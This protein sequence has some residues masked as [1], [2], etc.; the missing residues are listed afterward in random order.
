MSSNPDAPA[1]LNDD[2]PP[3][4]PPPGPPPS[5]P[6]A[7][8]NIE[9]NN[10]TSLMEGQEGA[11][12][13]SAAEASPE[14]QQEVAKMVLLMRVLNMA[15][16]VLLITVSIMNYDIKE[17]SLLVLAIYSTCGGLLVCLLETQLK[18]I[19][20][21]IAMNFG[22]LFNA[23]W[24]FVFYFLMASIAWQ[25]GSLFDK[26]V[27]IGLGA[28]AL[29]NTYVLCRYPSY[30]A[31]RDKIAEEEDKRIEAKISGEVKKQAQKQAMASMGFS[32]K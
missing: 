28:I 2:P 1:W 31:I 18:F 10:A 9:I 32:S 13:N 27:A 14:E 24:R 19:R 20:V 12:D 17:L 6:T 29:F 16:S 21:A 25:F 23:G 4:S 15:I 7:G 26:I 8:T 3:M 5:A 11:P 22:F 30:R